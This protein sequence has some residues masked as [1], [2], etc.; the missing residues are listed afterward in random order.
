VLEDIF[1]ALATSVT[2]VG[3]TRIGASSE[4]R[5]AKINEISFYSLTS[6][7]WD[8]LQ[9]ASEA[10]P[11]PSDSDYPDVSVQSSGYNTPQNPAF[12]HP[13]SPLAKVRGTRT[14][15]AAA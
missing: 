15:D 2:D 7:S 12:E 6:S 9:A 11:S 14:A 5:V 8:D 1:L 10:I 3:N 4:E 13:C